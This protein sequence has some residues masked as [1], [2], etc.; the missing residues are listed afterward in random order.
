MQI[1]A[2]LNSAKNTI[3]PINMSILPLF[4]IPW[5]PLF[6]YVPQMQLQTFHSSKC[7][8]TLLLT[9]H[10]TYNPHRNERKAI[11]PKLHQSN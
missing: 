9:I 11:E 8:R 7:T 4:Y 5:K 6:S 2:Q 3:L 10:I 1:R